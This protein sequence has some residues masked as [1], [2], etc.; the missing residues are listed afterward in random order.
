MVTGKSHKPTKFTR[1]V[2]YPLGAVIFFVVL[3][4]ILILANGYRFTYNSGKVG[5]TKTGMMIVATRP[6]DAQII[7]DGKKTKRNTGFYLLPTK[8]TG[9]KPAK[10]NIEISKS[11]YRTWKNTL[12]VK[13]NMVTWANYLL[14]FAEKLNISKQ[15]VPTGDIIA[16][17]DNGR[18]I[19][20]AS[21]A[22]KFDIK[23]FD[24]SNSDVKNFWPE[25]TPVETWLISPQIVS[26][27]F[28]QSNDRVLLKITNGTRTEYVVV[29]AS[30]NQPRLIHL[31]ITLKQDFEDAWW[32][33]SNNTEIYL[34]T[35]S[36]ISLVSVTGTELPTPLLTSAVSFK[37]DESRQIFY[38]SQSMKGL[39]SISRMDLNGNNKSVMVDN[40]L[41]SKSYNLGYSDQNNILTVLNDD[42][43]DLTAYYIGNSSKKYSIKLSS[44]VVSYRWSKDG[45]FLYY[46][47]DNFIKR[48][49][50]DKSKETNITFDKAPLSI[51][52]YF[53]ENHYL[54][55]DS[56]GIY[57]MDFDGSNIVPISE[58]EA[59]FYLLD[60]SNNNI[61]FTTKDDLGKETFYKFVSE[62]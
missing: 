35:K 1:L 50:W 23:S 24:T 32:S 42:T 59:S 19:L 51:E 57:I 47:G 10:Y 34:R 56:A 60:K 37:I 21:T 16:K 53:D 27:E 15:E 28:N 49:E 3:S 4:I 13:P 25:I 8:L 54:I 7:I 45:E 38:V 62:F 48:Y 33:I 58:T 2:L 40:I 6:Y 5:L 44:E 26:A 43:G 36:G 46:F 52:W 30:T 55:I 22:G 29:D 17:G 41:P 9:L 18:H 20:F 11:G 31:N 61:V 12:E 39:Y 14:L